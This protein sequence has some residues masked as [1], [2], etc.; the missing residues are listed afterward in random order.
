MIGYLDHAKFGIFNDR[1]EQVYYAF[2]GKNLNGRFSVRKKYC[3][4]SNFCARQYCPQT[5]RFQLH[6]VDS[7]NNVDI[8][9]TF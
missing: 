7:A 9:K 2:E 1:H 5:R 8:N 3:L 4:E 6:V